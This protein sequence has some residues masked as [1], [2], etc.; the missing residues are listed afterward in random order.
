MRFAEWNP[1]L[2]KSI[3][4]RR[5][6]DELQ[7]ERIE[8]VRLLESVERGNIRMVQ[9]G[10]QVRFP[11]ETG[12]PIVDRSM[13]LCI[14]VGAVPAVRRQHLDGHVAPEMGVVRAVDFAHTAPADGLDDGKASGHDVAGLEPIGRQEHAAVEEVVRLRVGAKHALHLGDEARVAA[15]GL[16]RPCLAART[17]AG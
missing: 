7:H 16:D 10:Q 5:A 8:A 15:A 14:R 3:R 12:E 13:R 2:R 11:P 4:Q 17:A 9:R 1:S 6:L